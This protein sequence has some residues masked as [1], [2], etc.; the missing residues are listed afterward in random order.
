MPLFLKPERFRR[1]HGTDHDLRE[2]VLRA[3]AGGS[4]D[5]W[6][7]IIEKNHTNILESLKNFE[8]SLEIV[9]TLISENDFNGLKQFLTKGSIFQR[10][11]NK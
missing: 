10:N 2:L 7:G 4:P 1:Q 8:N 11:L 5:L 9:R 3:P 6:T